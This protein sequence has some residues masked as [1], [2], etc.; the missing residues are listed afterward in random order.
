[1]LDLKKIFKYLKFAVLKPKIFIILFVLFFSTLAIAATL[2][3]TWKGAL[4]PGGNN[5]GG[6]GDCTATTNG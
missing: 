5:N 3:V 2:S 1:M 4:I 6:P